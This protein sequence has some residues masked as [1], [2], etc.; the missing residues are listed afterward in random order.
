MAIKQINQHHKVNFT[1]RADIIII[2]ILENTIQQTK[3][4]IDDEHNGMFYRKLY[5]IITRFPFD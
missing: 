1:R 3:H 5:N 4:Y 2:E